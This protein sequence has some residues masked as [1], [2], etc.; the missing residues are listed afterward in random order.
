MRKQISPAVAVILVIVAIVLIGAL[1]M[2][3]MQSNHEAKVI[4]QP[5]D[6]NNSLYK[7]DPKLNVDSSGT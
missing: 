3:V 1:G 4:V 2:K 5:A 6:P 7:P